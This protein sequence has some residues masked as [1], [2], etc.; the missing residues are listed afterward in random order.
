LS[1]TFVNTTYFLSFFAPPKFALLLSVNI[2]MA[3]FPK[4]LGISVSRY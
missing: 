2:V 1:L 4:N 3:F